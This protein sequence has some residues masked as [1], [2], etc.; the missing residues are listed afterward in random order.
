MPPSLAIP[1]EVPGLAA[2]TPVPA[3]ELLMEQVLPLEP[4]PGGGSVGTLW[5]PP[6]LAVPSESLACAVLPRPC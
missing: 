5:P 6:A 3:A 4:A 2:R 1:G